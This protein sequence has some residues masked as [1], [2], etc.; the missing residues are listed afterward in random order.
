MNRKP[1]KIDDEIRRGVRG[2][3]LSRAAIC[4]ASNLD[5]GHLT[6]FMGRQAGL[7]IS[8]LERLAAALSMQV[9]LRPLPDK[10]DKLDKR[11]RK[12]A[13]KCRTH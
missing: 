7:S 3:D 10:P 5:A 12:G 1:T 8:S 4:R 11:R 9:I 13:R 6:R 2:S